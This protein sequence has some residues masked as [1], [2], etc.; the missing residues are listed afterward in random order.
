[1][2]FDE[3]KE[4]LIR[5]S[6]WHEDYLICAL[7]IA[8]KIASWEEDDEDKYYAVKYGRRAITALCEVFAKER[9]KTMAPP[10]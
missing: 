5:N 1:V 6:V 3:A 9:S 8:T 4:Y 2:E 10:P 7:N